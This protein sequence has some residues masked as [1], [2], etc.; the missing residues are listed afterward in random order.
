MYFK[1]KLEDKPGA[2]LAVA[3]QLKAK[4]VG[5][6][7]LWGHS[8]QTG[9][10]RMYCV[11]KDADKFRNFA[12]A[13]GIAVE[14]GSGFLLRGADKTGALVKSLDTIAKAGANIVALHAIAAG[15]NYGAFVRVDPADI[16]KVGKALGA[17]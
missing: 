14:E 17:G 3:Q 5:L 15:G 11:P 4:N 12:K 1:A 7:A 8:T 9:E 10:A 2:A 16:E 6:V 13:A